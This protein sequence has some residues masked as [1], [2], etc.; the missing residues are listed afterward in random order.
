MP[1]QRGSRVHMTSTRNE[2]AV[3]LTFEVVSFVRSPPRIESNS[4]ASKGTAMSE[5]LHSI[6]YATSSGGTTLDQDQ[7]G[8]NPFATALIKLSLRPDLN[9]TQLLPALRRLTHK[10]SEKHQTPAWDVLPS[11]C[12][13]S[14]PLAAGSDRE[15]RIALVLIVSEYSP[16]PR[17]IGAAHDERRIASML[18]GHGFSVVQGIAPDRQSLVKALRSFAIKSKDFDVAVIYSTGHGVELGG[19]VFL[20]PGTYPRQHGDRASELRKHGI[21]VRQIAAACKALKVNLTFF[22]GCRTEMRDNNAR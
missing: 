20:L 8:G 1:S 15:R 22:A 9:L 4:L 21:S 5:P 3:I 11:N 14:F 13:W 2:V 16:A 19:Q 18:A 6:V 17:L 10:K 12:D 7:F